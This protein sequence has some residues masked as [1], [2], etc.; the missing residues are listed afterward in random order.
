MPSYVNLDLLNSARCSSRMEAAPLEGWAKS[1]TLG[2]LWRQKRLGKFWSIAVLI[3]TFLTYCGAPLATVEPVATPAPL[4]PTAAAPTSSPMPAHNAT[5]TPTPTLAATGNETMPAPTTESPN[6]EPQLRMVLIMAKSSQEVERLR[7]MRLDIVRVR[8][9][10]DQ[11]AVEGSLSGG[12]IVEAVV[13][14]GQLKKLETL[15]FD[16]SDVGSRQN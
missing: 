15:G 11:P 6:K 3:A 8:A 2:S 14:A 12:F 16:I 1:P 13:T 5:F 7:Q 4:T 9:N 10:P